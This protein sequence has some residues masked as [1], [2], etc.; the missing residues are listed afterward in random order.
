VSGFIALNFGGTVYPFNSGSIIGSDVASVV[1][2]ILFIIQ[3]AHSLFTTPEHRMFPADLIK[4]WELDILFAQTAAAIR[5]AF[6][7]VYFIPVCPTSIGI[8]T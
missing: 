6:I 1:L 2:W 7:P 8:K 4:I 3:Q 5:A